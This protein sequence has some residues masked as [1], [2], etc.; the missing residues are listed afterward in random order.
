MSR[1]KPTL[2]QMTSS[3]DNVVPSIT[4][5]IKNYEQIAIL[6]LLP[7][8][9]L[10]LGSHFLGDPFIQKSKLVLNAHLNTQQEI[11]LILVVV[12][13]LLSIINYPPAIYFRLKAVE[14]DKSPSLTDC[15]RNGLKLFGRVWLSQIISWIIILVGIILLIIPGVVFFRRY[16]LSP[17]YAA[18][19]PNLKLVEIFRRSAN[20]SKPFA[21]YIYSTFVI[22]ILINF[23]LSDILGPFTL[24]QVAAYI[25]SYTVLFLPSLRFSEILKASTLRK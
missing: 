22:I 3:W 14:T 11:G 16:I 7:S 4:L 2:T 10:I 8:L 23:V 21:N 20:Q 19:Y 15:Y 9:F 6:F 17:Y 1:T 25:L 18:K 13:L 5:A 12:W 24:G